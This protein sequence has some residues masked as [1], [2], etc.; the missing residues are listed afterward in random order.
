MVTRIWDQ[1]SSVIPNNHQD[2]TDLYVWEEVSVLS[3]GVI[4]AHRGSMR[5]YLRQ[6]N[7]IS[8]I[9]EIDEV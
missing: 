2:V 7:I 6:V 9:S 8:G 5:K 4:A 3:S 1:K